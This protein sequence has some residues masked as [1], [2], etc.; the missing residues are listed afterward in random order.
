M[1]NAVAQRKSNNTGSPRSCPNK[2]QISMIGKT[3]EPRTTAS[4]VV[5]LSKSTLKKES[6]C[7]SGEQCT[8]NLYTKNSLLKTRKRNCHSLAVV[9]EILHGCNQRRY[10]GTLDQFWFHYR[11]SEIYTSSVNTAFPT[12]CQKNIAKGLMRMRSTSYKS[13]SLSPACVCEFSLR[14]VC[15]NLRTWFLRGRVQHT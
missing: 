7:Y 2:E 6:K 11:K 3:V 12:H 15:Q 4:K 13:S 8:R 10:R 5:V 1:R 9:S 14:A